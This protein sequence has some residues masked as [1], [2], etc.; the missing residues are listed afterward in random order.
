MSNFYV[1]CLRIYPIKACAGT[2]VQQAQTGV[3]G[4]QYDRRWMLVNE[5]GEDL[6]Q[7]D[8]PQ[9]SGITASLNNDELHIQAPNMSE[10]HIP[11][12]PQQ[13]TSLSVQWFQGYCLAQPASEEADT[14]F[15]DYLH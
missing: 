11:I 14:W 2:D 6:H 12:Q 10:L 3:R 5:R 9:L 7:F 4:L 8:Y 13:A 1:S 15:Q